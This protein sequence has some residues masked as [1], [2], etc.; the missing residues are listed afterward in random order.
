MID[1]TGVHHLSLTHC[2]QAGVESTVLNKFTFSNLGTMKT[3]EM[4]C[5]PA[6][7]KRV[8]IVP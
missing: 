7:I 6:S 8:T 5:D 4:N 3:S 2:Q 1:Y